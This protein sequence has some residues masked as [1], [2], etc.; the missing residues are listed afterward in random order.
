MFV[1][2]KNLQKITILSHKKVELGGSSLIDSDYINN[3]TVAV[4][5]SII[6]EYTKSETFGNIPTKKFTYFENASTLGSATY[7]WNVLDEAA[8]T[9][10][11][12]YV[13]GTLSA[14]LEFPSE[15]DGYKVVAISPNAIS[16][17]SDDVTKIVL[18]DNMEYLTFN[19]S[20]LTTGIKALEIADSNS[21]FKT[22][23]GVLYSE[24]GKVLYI[25]PKSKESTAFTVNATV[26]E[27]AYRAFYQDEKQVSALETL[28][29]AGVVTIRDQAFENS[30][31]G[32]IKFTSTTASVF[33]G[34]D[35]LLGA[36]SLLRISVP[37][38]SLGAFKS[39][40]LMDYSILGRFIGA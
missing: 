35:I 22:V 39:N 36:N 19:T 6:N 26:T 3:V 9:A 29:I 40:V 15:F 24:D 1:G 37:N 34:K 23:D 31:I 32:L 25:Y 13:E 33:A 28:T 7:Y 4:P 14:T 18:P 12:D 2:A 21:K 38:A 8:K 20:D 17:L 27:I 5:Q 16:S 30:S 11:I 10:Y